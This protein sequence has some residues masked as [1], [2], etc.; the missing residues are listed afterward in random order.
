MKIYLAARYSRRDELNGYRRALEARGHVVT[1]RW[2]SGTHQLGGDGLSVQ[3]ADA[4][5]ERFASEDLADVMAAEVVISFT[6]EPRKT[7]G[8]G[9][10]HVEFGVAYASGKTCVVIGPRENVFHHLPGVAYFPGFYAW[11]EQQP[12]TVRPEVMP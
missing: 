4:E 11:L 3:A 8:R 5:R 10:R 12:P 6:E 9:G 1:S 7:N 2:L